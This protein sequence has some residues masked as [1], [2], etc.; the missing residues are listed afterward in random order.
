MSEASDHIEIRVATADDL[1][2]MIDRDLRAFSGSFTFDERVAWRELLDFDR[3]RVA[4]DGADLVGPAGSHELELTLPGGALVPMGGTTWVSVAP[5]HRRRGILTRLIGDVHDDIAARNEPIAGLLASEGSIYER[6]GYGV[7]TRLRVV[8]MDTRNAQVARP[9]TDQLRMINPLKRIDALSERYDRYRRGRVGEASRSADWLTMRLKECKQPFG[10][11]HDDGYAIWTID[12]DWGEA[13][14][15]H[16]LRVIDI[17]AATDEAYA[18]LW[19]FVLSVDL[20]RTVVARSPLTLDDPLPYLL[21]DQRAVRTSAVHDFLQLRPMD[22]AALFGARRYRVPDRMVIQVTDEALVTADS[23]GSKWLI[24]GGPEAASCELVDDCE[25]DLVMTRAAA[26]SLLL[27]G[28]SASELAAGS[29]LAGRELSRADAFF[30]WSPLAH[31][32]TAF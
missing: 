17:V 25:P 28:V 20:V 21:T 24:V 1:D 10:V 31:C 32:T 8:E 15:A 19:N 9:P 5:T 27:G 4:Y 6:F 23:R 14:P 12:D 29:R 3:F 16:T 22:I 11:L 30:G 26:G 18:S 13:E 2:A 7:A